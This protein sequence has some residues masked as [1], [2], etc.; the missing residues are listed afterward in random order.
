MKPTSNLAVLMIVYVVPMTKAVPMI[1]LNTNALV[2]R[3]DSNGIITPSQPQINTNSCNFTI[4]AVLTWFKRDIVIGYW[5]LGDRQE[6]L[7]LGREIDGE[8]N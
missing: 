1:E 4:L 5:D 6:L 3:D 8:I 2:Q 7:E